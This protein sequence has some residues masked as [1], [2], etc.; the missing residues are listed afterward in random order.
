MSTG[1]DFVM[2]VKNSLNYSR[3]IGIYSG[4]GV[5]LGLA[6]HITYCAIG[7][8]VLISRYPIVFNIIKFAGAA[9]LVYMGIGS[10]FSK[11]SKIQVEENTP[12]KSINN[13]EA[14]RIGF[15]T[16]VLNPKATLFFFGLFTFVVTPKIPL[17]IILIIA[18]IIIATA[19]VWFTLVSVFF[20]QKLVKETF[21]KFEKKIN[22]V[23]GCL[24][25]L[26]AVKIALMSL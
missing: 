24:L 17:P 6:V 5:G 14:F 20:T 1:P 19:I 4:I 26:L 18:I 3:K 23:L 13:W 25:I 7:I 10:I 15:L 21:L 22:V 12:E 16:N 11:A 2:V 8:A 9:Y